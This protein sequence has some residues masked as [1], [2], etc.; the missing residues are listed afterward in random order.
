L[1]ADQRISRRAG[2]PSGQ[3]SAVITICKYDDYQF[4]EMVAGE[5]T[6]SS[7]A[8][9]PEKADMPL[10]LPLD[11]PIGGP[12]TNETPRFEGALMSARTETGGPKDQPSG[13]PKGGPSSKNGQQLEEGLNNKRNNAR[14]RA[15]DPVGFTEWYG[16]YPKKAARKHAAKMFGRVI[17]AGEISIE[18][19]MKR[20][21]T[22]AA[23]WDRRPKAE[24]KFIPDPGT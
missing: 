10:D 8:D 4:G 2:K 9:H 1:E 17:T 15:G 24:H 21:A 5:P 12:K 16:V 20:T 14:S 23:V 6:G 19:L 22:F 13:G 3:P 11:Q 7:G 18:L